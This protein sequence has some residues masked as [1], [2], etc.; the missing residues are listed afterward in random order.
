MLE[1]FTF[2][3]AKCDGSNTFFGLPAWY[4][5]L[6]MQEVSGRCQLVDSFAFPNDLAL[7]A[8]ALLEIALRLAGLVAIGFVIYGGFQ[9][10]TSQG[11]PEASKHAR[12]T[13]INAV[14][15]L[16]IALFATAF[17]AF[18]GTRLVVR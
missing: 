7:V 18:I 2:F 13:I 9:F 16:I 6:K 8:L 12:Q 11:D 5:Y 17:V 14:I 10:V 3:A 1:L 15:G 4:K